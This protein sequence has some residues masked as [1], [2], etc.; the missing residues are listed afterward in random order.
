MLSETL[1]HLAMLVYFSV[2]SAHGVHFDWRAG[3]Q[4]AVKVEEKIVLRESSMS[5]KLGLDLET[6]AR[7]DKDVIA[8]QSNASEFKRALGLGEQIA[9][10]APEK[11]LLADRWHDKFAVTW[12]Q[13]NG[14][15]F[16]GR[17]YPLPIRVA[18][19][20]ITIEPRFVSG[21]GNFDLPDVKPALNCEP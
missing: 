18:E 7:P 9:K 15:S 8:L 11:P 13:E 2:S 16:S 4:A 6:V 21:F 1:I 10:Q 14:F 3:K 12:D 19:S 5:E 17:R 20:V